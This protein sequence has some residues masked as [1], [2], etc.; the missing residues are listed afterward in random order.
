MEVF[1]LS[2]RDNNMPSKFSDTFFFLQEL[3]AKGANT[4]CSID[5]SF[6]SYWC[7]ETQSNTNLFHLNRQL[8]ELT[9]SLLL[10]LR[11]NE[12]HGDD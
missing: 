12:L 10:E 9:L 1:I 3:E 4:H 8:L 6:G 5:T 7:H 2:Y 11:H